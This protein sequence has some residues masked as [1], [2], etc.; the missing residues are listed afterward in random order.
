MYGLRCINNVYSEHCGNRSDF[1]IVGHP[2]WNVGK[3]NSQNGLDPP[4]ITRN[5]VPKWD[6]RPVKMHLARSPANDRLRLSGSG[7][8]VQK[9]HAGRS[10]KCGTLK[11]RALAKSSSDSSLRSSGAGG[12]LA[13]TDVR[14]SFNAFVAALSKPLPPIDPPSASLPAGSCNHLGASGTQ[15]HYAA[16]KEELEGIRDRLRRD[17]EHTQQELLVSGSWKYYAL[18]LETA[19]RFEDVRQLALRKDLPRITEANIFPAP[20]LKRKGF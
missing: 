12:G 20:K 4:K 17:P 9:L 11:E 1:I 13:P 14:C 16:V 19:R 10:E 5:A 6:E 3:V 2:Q 18:K 8:L 15:R 7:Q